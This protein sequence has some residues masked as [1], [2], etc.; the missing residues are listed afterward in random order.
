LVERFI[1]WHLIGY[2]KNIFNLI[3][4]YNIQVNKKKME[5]EQE[6]LQ[7]PLHFF[8]E[9]KSN[10]KVKHAANYTQR[11]LSGIC[12]EKNVLALANGPFV[13]LYLLHQLEKISTTKCHLPLLGQILLKEFLPDHY[14]HNTSVT[15]VLFLQQSSVL[16]VGAFVEDDQ[17]SWLFGFRYYLSNLTA[18]RTSSKDSNDSIKDIEDQILTHLIFADKITPSATSTTSGIRSIGDGISYMETTSSSTLQNG[19]VFFLL[20]NS[21]KF[22]IMIWSDRLTDRMVSIAQV[23]SSTS[24]LA[25]GAIKCDEN[26]NGNL[27]V[28][29]DISGGI[30]L[31]DMSRFQWAIETTVGIPKAIAGKRLQNITTIHTSTRQVLQHDH[32]LDVVRITYSSSGTTDEILEATPNLHFIS[33][34]SWLCMKE[35]TFL[36]AAVTDGSMRLFRCTG[37]ALE[38][39][40][41]S[42]VRKYIPQSL[43]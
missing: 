36:W 42:L 27:I 10:L 3:F 25:N 38:T 4:I 24:C 22:G 21:R 11:Q 16:F 13:D 15:S 5:M 26:N 35:E 18:S 2:K 33:S 43:N 41:V 19:A 40:R 1:Q 37:C 20:A 9:S 23:S 39:I 14:E 29:S 8:D 12:Q 28:L 34:F 31:L 7:A 30:H 32:P 17:S 6:I